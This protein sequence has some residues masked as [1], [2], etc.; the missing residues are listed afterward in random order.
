MR[1]NPNGT[2]RIT[3]KSGRDPIDVRPE[4]LI[5]YNPSLL[6]DYNKYIEEQKIF[7]SG[8]QGQTEEERKQQ[9]KEEK[10][11]I[12]IDQLFDLYY[13]KPGEESLALTAPGEY[14]L[15]AQ[16]K[17]L[18]TKF[19]AG[20]VNSIE[21][22]IYKYNRIL[23]SKRA[24]L[25]KAAG[26]SG[27]LALQEQILAGKGLPGPDATPNEAIG[28]FDS[29]YKVFAGGKKP[30]KLDEELMK[31]EQGQNATSTQNQTGL[32]NI[33]RVSPKKPDRGLIGGTPLADIFFPGIE[34]ARKKQERNEQLTVGDKVA[35]LGD[36]AT[37][38]IPIA[39][40]GA[41]GKAGFAAKSALTGGIRGGTLPNIG[42]LGERA[43]SAAIGTLLGGVV[44]KLPRIITPAR[45]GKGIR[46]RAVE[47]AQ[48]AGKQIEGNK[49]VK[50]IQEWAITAK[51]ANPGKGNQVTKIVD[52]ATK[53]YKN[54]NISPSQAKN[55]WNEVNSGFTQGGITKTTVESSADRALRDLL[56]RE[57]DVA[58]PGFEKGT[59][60]IR[61][62]LN[63]GQF[64]KRAIFPT[65]I[66]AGIGVPL[67]IGLSKI[68]GGRE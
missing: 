9:K 38:A 16:L 60:L 51:Q 34:N 29:A 31:A 54:K 41:L 13:G 57:L 39:K 59:K 68:L 23:E 4:E 44:G 37:L 8:T 25:A 18:E 26:D 12:V 42:D 28:L 47:A 36:I 1:I 64:L 46:E 6:G 32:P 43:K 24:Q 21:E 55:I 49:F 67:S 61:E 19:K 27:N 35:V 48:A 53:Q 10:S 65:A 56:R 3:R 22:R 52:E 20:E 66:G 45:V 2:V 11:K 58:A 30:P 15:P 7:G 63:R 62:G 17:T 33:P 50:G 5:N 14:R 40:V